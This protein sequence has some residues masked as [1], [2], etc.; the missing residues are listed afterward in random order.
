MPPIS[1]TPSPV[2]I[3]W[4]FHERGRSS[5]TRSGGRQR[6]GDVHSS[7]SVRGSVGRRSRA[8]RLIVD[9]ETGRTTT[10]TT[11]RHRNAVYTS[12]S[13]S[14]DTFRLYMR[15]RSAVFPR[16]ENYNF[17]LKQRPASGSSV[18]VAKN[19][20]GCRILETVYGPF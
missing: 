12:R 13:L 3:K 8:G 10:I 5:T 18:V 11:V 6:S 1:P 15:R 19:Y 2:Q 9:D 17:A 16:L 7:R 4:R 20:D 14:S